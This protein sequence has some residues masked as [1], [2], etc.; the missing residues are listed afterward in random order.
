[1]TYE[2]QEQ[3]VFYVIQWVY[4]LIQLSALFGLWWA[5]RGVKL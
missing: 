5:R 1:M 4:A 2:Q 3:W